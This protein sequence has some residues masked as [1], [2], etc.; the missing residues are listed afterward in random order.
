MHRPRTDRRT[1]TRGV[2]ILERLVFPRSERPLW[3]GAHQPPRRTWRSESAGRPKLHKMV[4]NTDWSS[5]AGKITLPTGAQSRV[6]TTTGC[7]RPTST[8]TRSRG[9][10]YQRR[11]TP[12]IPRV[13][14]QSEPTHHRQEGSAPPRLVEYHIRPM[15][16]T[17]HRRMEHGERDRH[18]ELPSVPSKETASP[19]PFG[20]T[21]LPL[22]PLSHER[23]GDQSLLPLAGMNSCQVLSPARINRTEELVPHHQ[24]PKPAPST[25]VKLASEVSLLQSVVSRAAA[26]YNDRLMTISGSDQR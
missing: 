21:R 14:R 11:T 12:L 13:W 17:L 23:L 9:V 7:A 22:E 5:P 8:E 18:R 1:I 6:L 24:K 15:S 3:G 2:D 20:D 25:K 4:V 19:M 10:S 16:A 26:T